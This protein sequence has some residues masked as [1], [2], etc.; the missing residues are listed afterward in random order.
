MTETLEQLSDRELSELAAFADGSL[1]PSRRAQVSARV[2]RSAELRALVAEQR[3]A[4]A[5]VSGVL[6]LLV[7]RSSTGM[8]EASPLGRR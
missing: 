7:V 1:P 6:A 2:E 5:A 8:V 3:S 4:L